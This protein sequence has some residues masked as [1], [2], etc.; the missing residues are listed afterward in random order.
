MSRSICLL[1][2]L[3]LVCFVST[4][5]AETG[6]YPL[7][8]EGIKAATLP[9]PGLYLRTY[10]S[11]YSANTL[12]DRSGKNVPFDFEVDAFAFVPRLVWMTG[13]KFLGAEYGMDALL[14]L[15]STDIDMAPGGMKLHFDECEFGDFFFEPVDLIWRG[16][17]FDLALAYGLWFPT[18]DSDPANPAMAGKGFWTNM[19]T[20]GGTLYFDEE[21]TWSA[22]ALGRYEIHSEEKYAEVRPGRNLLFEW[23]VA[24]TIEKI[25]D[26]GVVGYAQWQ[27]S[28]DKGDDVTWDPGIHDRVAAVGP[29]VSVFIPPAKMFV[30][31]RWNFEFSAVDRPEGHAATLTVT[32]IF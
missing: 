9:P 30:S 26:V 32:K 17:N 1:V 7:G 15:V 5:L 28:D 4:A 12:K 14:P 6:H 2:A 29:E 27:L 19:F 21:K 3:L 20:F 22:S 8:S 11:F 16:D 31:L 13:E 24:K 25:V 10:S 18:G 23:G